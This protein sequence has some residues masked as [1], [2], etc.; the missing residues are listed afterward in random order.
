VQAIKLAREDALNSQGSD[1]ELHKGAQTQRQRNSRSVP[2]V[3]LNGSLHGLQQPRPY[4]YHSQLNCS[5]SAHRRL[6]SDDVD[7]LPPA[8][9][10]NLVCSGSTLVL[11]T[12]HSLQHLN[13]NGNTAPHVSTGGAPPAYETLQSTRSTP[14][15]A[16]PPRPKPAWRLF[17]D[18][19]I[20]LLIDPKFF[21]PSLANLFGAIGLFIPF[22]YLV[23]RADMEYKI[24]RTQASFLLSVIGITN[25]LGRLV[26]GAVA[27]IKGVNS[28][29][30]HN[31]ALILAGVSCLLVV[32]CVSYPIMCLFAAFFGLC[33]ATWISL[34]SIVLCDLLGLQRLT[35]AFSLLTMTR[36]IATTIGSPMA[37]SLFDL[38]GDYNSPFYLGGTSLIVGGTL[39]SLLH[40]ACCRNGRVKNSGQSMGDEDLEKLRLPEKLDIM[41][42][43]SGTTTPLL[44]V[45]PAVN[46]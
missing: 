2:M 27:N 16:T 44:T 25:T 3:T 21:L 12:A 22:V 20:A 4:I 33:I 39:C 6:S 11:P 1:M 13:S 43:N 31:V 34:T 18:D 19:Y 5:N 15:S 30:L 10:R 36:G 42:E 40:L 45:T 23:D 41:R 32:F 17:L 14:T 9:L 26:A 28:L 29:L 37:G 8:E 38:T 46:A 35:N 24:P 7:L